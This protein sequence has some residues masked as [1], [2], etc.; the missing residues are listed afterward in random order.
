MSRLS[1]GKRKNL[2]EL[3]SAPVRSK[4]SRGTSSKANIQVIF[5]TIEETILEH[6]SDLHCKN[7]VIM[8]PYFSN[9]RILKACSGMEGCS[10]VT[11]YDKG[12]RSKVRADLFNDLSPLLNGRVRTLNAGCGR[13]KTLLHT[14][15]VILLDNERRPFKVL[16]GSFNLS[17]NAANNIEQFTVYNCP[18]VATAFYNEFKRVWGISKTFM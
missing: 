14:K 17:E 1:K 13:N 16:A 6:L 15:A 8:A 12:M 4:R 2:N 7:V 5:D 18:I 3:F 9:K 11:N 10:I